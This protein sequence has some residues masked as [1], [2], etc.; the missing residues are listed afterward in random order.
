MYP[1]GLYHLLNV[2]KKKKI[3]GFTHVYKLAFGFALS[4]KP[5]A[6]ASEATQQLLNLSLNRPL[7][8]PTY[9]SLYLSLSLSLSLLIA[10]FHSACAF[11]T[12]HRF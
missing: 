1:V 10:F 11:F 2:K 4:G 3:S 7:L 9:L 12:P 6:G 5:V 8:L